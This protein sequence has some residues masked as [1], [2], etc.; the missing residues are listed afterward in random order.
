MPLVQLPEENSKDH[1]NEVQGKYS[2]VSAPGKDIYSCIENN[3]FVSE[4]GTS[5]A[6]PVVAGSVALIG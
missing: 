1:R 3:K 5:M 4:S 2:T 6:A